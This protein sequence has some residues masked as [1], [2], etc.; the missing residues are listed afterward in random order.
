[1]TAGFGLRASGLERRAS[2][3][4][5]RASGVR[6]A[7]LTV[8]LMAPAQPALAQQPAAPFSVRGEAILGYQHFLAS[9]TFKGVFGTANAPIFGGGIDVS[10]LKHWFVRVDATRFSKTGERA[11][12]A[13]GIVYQ[14]GIPLTVTIT[15]VTVAAG[16]RA[17]F[18][19]KPPP[20]SSRYTPPKPATL[21]WYAGGGA[22]SWSYSEKTDDPTETVSFRKSGFLALGGIEWRVQ[23]YVALGFEGQYASV[24]GAVG[25]GGISEQFNEKDI[26]GASAV[27]RMVVGR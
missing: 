25:S 6:A 21:F 5:L 17:P 24:P 14:L 2:G 13:K 26:G 20:R 23:K 7:V 27:L 15:P 9:Q 8:A 4:R 12:V 22:G 18:P 19:T 11:F 16:Y 10:F 3:V 1:M